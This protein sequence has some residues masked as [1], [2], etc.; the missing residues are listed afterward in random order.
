MDSVSSYQD[1]ALLE[2]DLKPTKEGKPNSSILFGEGIV[3]REKVRATYYTPTLPSL[4]LTIL[5]AQCSVSEDGKYRL[6]VRPNPRRRGQRSSSRPHSTDYIR[7]SLLVELVELEYYMINGKTR[8]I[9]MSEYAKFLIDLII[10]MR[11]MRGVSLDVRTMGGKRVETLNEIHGTL[12]P[13][14]PSPDCVLRLWF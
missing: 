13:T 1:L 11:G 6:V 2:A 3:A 10:F 5:V 12:G 7:M 8:P 14:N 9:S 4:A